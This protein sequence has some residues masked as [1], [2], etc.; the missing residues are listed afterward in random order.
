MSV[1]QADFPAGGFFVVAGEGVA[2]L[3]SWL[4]GWEMVVV[5]VLVV[6]A[7]ASLAVTLRWDDK[8]NGLAR[9]SPVSI[10]GGMAWEGWR[11]WRDMLV[12]VSQRDGSESNKKENQHEF[13]EIGKWGCQVS[14][15]AHLCLV[16]IHMTNNFHVFPSHFSYTYFKIIPNLF[17]YLK[18]TTDK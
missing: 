11:R 7:L 1:V 14:P 9:S 4:L 8:S 5:V 12:C 17:I 2:C 6:A 15:H 13:M 16:L 3:V 18:T 10:S